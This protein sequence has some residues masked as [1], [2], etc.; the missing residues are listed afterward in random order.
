VIHAVILAGGRGER[1]WPLSRA[2]R[3]KQ[4][5]PLVGDRTLLA[6]TAARL[7]PLVPLERS[8]VITGADQ[9][10]LVRESLPGIDP[11]HV[12]AEPMG[13]NTAPAVAVGAHLALTRDPDAVIV[14]VPSDAWIGD[15]AAYRA[16]LAAAVEAAGKE[17]VLV[18]IGAVPNRPETGYGYLEIADPSARVQPVLQFVEKPDAETAVR[19]VTGGR[20]LW[21]CG[22]FVMKARVFTAALD[23]HLPEVGGALKN[24]DA[25]GLTAFYEAVPSISIDYGVMEKAANVAT[26]RA[27][28]A[29]DDLGSW[30]ALT[31]VL[32]AE[33]HGDVLALESDG[34]VLYAEE[35]LIAALGVPGLVVVRTPR[36]VL[37]LPKERAQEV[38]RIVRELGENPRWKSYL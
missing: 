26:V 22:I 8:Y 15:E 33:G 16:A 27:A 24:L 37:V 1:F 6:A 38:R 7:A 20:H 36:A 28:F 19:Y 18:T 9:A 17:D 2:G 21:N 34:A 5:L 35:G 4:F 13:K 30:S 32:P 25:G 14:V 12:V 31:R 11:G 29:W 3:A 10:D 23:L